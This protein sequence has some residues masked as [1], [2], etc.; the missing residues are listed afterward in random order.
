MNSQNINRSSIPFGN[1][2]IPP[3]VPLSLIFH[4]EHRLVFPDKN[5]C[6]PLVGVITIPV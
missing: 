3:T 1:F 4:F 5:Q 6:Y 2:L